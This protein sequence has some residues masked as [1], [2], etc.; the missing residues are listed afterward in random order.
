MVLLKRIQNALKLTVELS[1][2]TTDAKGRLTEITERIKDF[3]AKSKP[4]IDEQIKLPESDKQI[5]VCIQSLKKLRA[6]LRS[7]HSKGKWIPRCL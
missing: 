7:E 1:N 3:D 2:K 5:I 6:L 4:P